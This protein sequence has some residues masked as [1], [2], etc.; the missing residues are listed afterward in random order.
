MIALVPT[1]P[2]V[3]TDPSY[4]QELGRIALWLEPDDLRWLAQRCCCDDGTAVWGAGD[5][6]A[7]PIQ[8]TR[9]SSQGRPLTKR[10]VPIAIASKKPT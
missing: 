5:L 10:Y 2:P 7:H 6:R 1:D 8:G 9:R 4:E 3:P